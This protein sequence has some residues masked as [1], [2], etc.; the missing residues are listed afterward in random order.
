MSDYSH[1]ITSHSRAGACTCQPSTPTGVS[2]AF[3]SAIRIV[4][5]WHGRA[6]QRQDLRDL[7]DHLLDDIGITRKAT[8]T[9]ALKPFWQ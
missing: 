9:E 8:E 2:S 4:S 3:R 7:N 6:R 5:R 1:A